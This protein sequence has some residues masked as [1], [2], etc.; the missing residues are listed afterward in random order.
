MKRN[1]EKPIAEFPGPIEATSIKH[2]ATV[3]STN[4]AR[5]NNP[6]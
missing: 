5:N 1:Y 4:A 3:H 6:A 2:S